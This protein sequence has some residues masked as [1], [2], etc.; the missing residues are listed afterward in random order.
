[1]L[2][3]LSAFFSIAETSMMA[4]NRYRLKAMVRVGHRGARI[5]AELLAQ[6]DK[7]LGVILLG[8][9]L[10]AA[11][12][13]TLAAMIAHSL[14]GKAMK[15]DHKTVFAIASWFIFAALLAGRYFRGWRGRTALRWSLAGFVMVVL[16]NIGTAFVLEVLLRR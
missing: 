10:V 3:V 2:L 7:L 14:F 11:G 12:A 4:L 5:V 13:A 16:A 6:I 9:T 1:M 15:F 8:N